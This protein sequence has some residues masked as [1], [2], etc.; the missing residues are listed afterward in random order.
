[1]S[2]TK[3]KAMSDLMSDTMSKKYTKSTLHVDAHEVML[4]TAETTMIRL[5]PATCCPVAVTIII[6]NS[7]LLTLRKTKKYCDIIKENQSLIHKER[8]FT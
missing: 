8:K 5:E 2:C 7:N 6:M 1:M 4:G 3:D